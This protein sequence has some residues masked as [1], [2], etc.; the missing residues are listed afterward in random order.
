MCLS[1]GDR[2]GQVWPDLLGAVVG[3]CIEYL[4]IITGLRALV[5]LAVLFYLGALLLLMR[6]GK[7][8]QPVSPLH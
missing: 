1:S 7:R 3:G 2:Q 5:L 4:S 8:L 6:R